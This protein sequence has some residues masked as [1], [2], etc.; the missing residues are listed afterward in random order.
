MTRKD[1]SLHMELHGE[2]WHVNVDKGQIEQLLLNLFINAVEA[3]PKGGN[4]YI[5]TKNVSYQATQRK[6]VEI[7]AGDYIRLIIEDT[8]IGMDKKTIKRIFEP[9]F[10]TKE[11]GKGTG[12]GLASVYGIVKG[13]GGYI[14][15]KSNQGEKTTFEIYMPAHKR[16]IV[17][18]ENK[19]GDIIKGDGTVLLVDDDETIIEV[20]QNM[21]RVIGYDVLIAS[22]GKEAIEKY[23]Q[24]HENIQIVILDM[25]MP[26]MNGSDTYDRLKEINPDIKV[27]LSS[28]YNKDGMAA[29]I[30]NRGCN[31]FIQKPF[32]LKELSL[33]LFNLVEN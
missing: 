24:Y 21:L 25:I 19:I 31:G 8:G 22:N 11:Q 23:K 26:E 29:E 28:G 2:L 1:I 10:T 18:K 16:K 3:M 7:E 6:P 9:F 5:K 14:H 27:L 20:G 15:V 33:N 13:H 30:L 12:L 17:Q 32:H 4:L